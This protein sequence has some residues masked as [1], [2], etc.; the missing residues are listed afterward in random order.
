MKN[1]LLFL[2][3]ITTFFLF[4]EN[5]LHANDLIFNTAEIKILNNGNTIVTTDGTV[6]S[7]D[8]KIMLKAKSFNYDKTTE[9]LNAKNGT[10]LL[11][12]KRIEIK[13]NKFIYNKNLS[14]IEATG[15]VE[16]K[17]LDKNVTIK[18]QNISYYNFEQIIKSETK[19]TIKD[20]FNNFFTTS[21]FVYTINDHLVKIT[22]GKLTDAQKNIINIEKGYINLL[23]G[24]LI[25]KDISIDFD[26]VNF[27]HDNEPRLAGNTIVSNGEETIIKKAVFTTC[28]KSDSCPPWQFLAQEIKHDKKK[29]IIFY[30]KAWLKIYDKPVFYFPKF[31][32][33]DPTVKRQSGFLMPTFKNSTSTGESL[34]VPYYHV[35]SYNKDFTV[36]PR[37]YSNNKLLAQVEYRQISPAIDHTI[38]MSILGDKGAGTK[39]HFF[40]NSIKKLNFNKF[41]N[42]Q[43]AFQL[44]QTSAD[45]YLK[46]YKLKSPLINNSNTLSSF[47]EINTYREDLSIKTNFQV[48]EDLSKKNNDRYEFILPNFD[49][50]K[51]FKTNEKI[52]GD[53]ILNTSGHVKNYNTNIFE[54][55]LVNDLTFNSNTKFFNNGLK[56][57]Y[58]F[59]FKN[60]NTDSKNSLLYKNTLNNEIAAIGEFNTA[61]PLK[62]E[63]EMHTSILK[64]LI[65]LRYSPN[66]SKNLRGDER[67]IDSSNIYSLNRI[68]SNTS[69]EGGL[70]ITYGTEFVRFDNN[71]NEI[72]GANI[73][74]VIKN[75]A[76]DQISRSS[77]LG[78]K[79][80]DIIGGLRL[81]LNDN[82][83]IK[84]DFSQDS[85]LKDTNFQ[86]IESEF[87]VN[88]FVT[89]FEYLNEN[90]TIKQQSYITNQTSYTMSDSKNIIFKTRKNKKTKLTEFYNLM[91]QYRNDC[92]VAGIEY[93]KEY[94]NSGKLKPEENIFIK[95]T[96]IPMGETKSPNLKK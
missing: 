88:N 48:F 35:L 63:T 86:I 18:S 68:G 56:N 28:K 40:S 77:S 93:N 7:S 53:F 13:A 62:K 15:N 73:A 39:S 30:E 69:V 24:K 9:I 82:I 5:K 81:N 41:D 66:D 37:F 49:M 78:N 67:R 12:E 96:I 20:N 36:N 80:S 94:Y 3:L 55:T 74:N 6:N 89:S 51:Y 2:F 19:S 29:K 21:N 91:Y 84:Y 59:L 27:A 60:V 46:S 71:D 42:S 87:K 58:N 76:D 4:N 50:K 25:G 92:L 10:A 8:N 61:Y 64:P 44:Q 17:D 33:P 47:L 83:K 95:L 79:T 52:N 72:F 43:V 57:N 65:S 32:H 38:D 26:N 31:F 45:D 11:V 90:N 22:D 23:S 16:I 70:S 85:N 75:E 54:K 14:T 34:I 1:N